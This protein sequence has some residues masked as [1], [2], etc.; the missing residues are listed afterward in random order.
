MFP[1]AYNLCNKNGLKQIKLMNWIKKTARV[2]TGFKIV[3]PEESYVSISRFL[4]F[5]SIL[6]V[7][8]KGLT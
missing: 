6:E 5:K 4:V 3:K 7:Q 2:S 1:M 8:T